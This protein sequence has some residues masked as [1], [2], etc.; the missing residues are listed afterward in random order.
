MSCFSVGL[1][2]LLAE[3]IL[4]N[5]LRWNNNIIMIRL[6]YFCLKNDSVLWVSSRNTMIIMA[7]LTQASGSRSLLK[8]YVPR[9]ID[10]F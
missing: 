9:K 10:L 1:Q 7:N 3:E 8:C 4:E 5:R 6:S 2:A